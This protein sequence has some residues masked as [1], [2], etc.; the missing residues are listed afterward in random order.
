L[1]LGFCK[2]IIINVI[3]FCILL[4]SLECSY[5][6]WL[7]FRNCETVCYNA[8]FLTKLDAFNRHIIKSGVYRFLASDPST[9]YS[10]ADGTFRVHEWNDATVTIRQ[11]VRVNTD[12]TPT[13]I[14]D[15]ILAV[16]DS[17]V[18]GDQVSDDETW[19]ALLERR[20]NRRVANGGVSAYGTA[21]A[22][23]RAERL[24][25]SGPYSLLILSIL[26]NT[27]FWRD[28]DVMTG[29]SYRPV[30]IREEDGRLRQ[31]TVQESRKIFSESL[32]CGH[33]RIPEFFFWSYIAKVAFSKLGYDGR[34]TKLIAPK[35]A[36]VHE[37]LEFVVERLAAFPV[38]KVI[39]IQY[40][41]YLLEGIGEHAGRQG[42]DEARMIREA[43]NRHGV[44]V[45][46]TY[47]ALK[48]Y[49]LRETYD[50]RPHHSEKGNQVI[51]DL[52]AREIR[53][54][55]S[56]APVTAKGAPGFSL[57]PVNP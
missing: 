9:G 43:A 5:R 24:L 48:N 49:P 56:P 32:I 47:D 19:P 28:R 39:L 31:T 54:A 29:I 57:S 10:P 16:G 23:L 18:F 40:P 30:V 15:A 34:C 1:H 42:I 35:A 33:P 38:K 27:D 41:R 36:T 52:I 44:P 21:Q 25:N 7:Y 3:V 46:D 50:D 53:G 12:F 20:L 37:I 8:V 6:V 13:S 45:I 2:S 22:V 14:D 17:F 11:G 26:V 51:A 4:V 55:P